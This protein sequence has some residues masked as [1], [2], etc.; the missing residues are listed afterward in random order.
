[1]KKILLFIIR[2]LYSY[3]IPIKSK[4]EKTVP[5]VRG[6]AIFGKKGVKVYSHVEIPN[7]SPLSV[8]ENVTIF[9]NVR[10]QCSEESPIQISDNVQVY[11]HSVIQS[12]GGGISIGKNVI[13]GEYTTIQAQSNV[14]IEDDVLLASKIQIITNAHMYD[15][16]DIPI[17]YQR[18]Q[19]KPVLIKKGAWIGINC[20]ILSGVTIGKNSVVGAGS[21]VNR[22]VPDYCVVAGIPARTIKKFNKRTNNWENE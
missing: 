9:S 16:I 15:D 6:Y 12:L 3:Y 13:I 19:S 21:I 17:K 5:K 22:D 7:V 11:D 8:G 14:T 20:T 10:F 18:N 1:M 4:V 2:L